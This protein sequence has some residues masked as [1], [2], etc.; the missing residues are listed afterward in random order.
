[1]PRQ[2]NWSIATPQIQ[3][4]QPGNGSL[5]VQNTDHLEQPPGREE[6]LTSSPKHDELR[7]DDLIPQNAAAASWPGAAATWQPDQNDSLFPTF[8]I[9]PTSD[10]QIET[11]RIGIGHNGPPLEDLGW[12]WLT[13]RALGGSAA[14][15]IAAIL[16]TPLNRGEVEYIASR[17]ARPYGQLSRRL[18]PGFQAHHLNQN[19]AFREVIPQNDGI[20]VG[21]RG[22]A[23]T[24][25]GTPHYMFHQSLEQFWEPYRSGGN[26]HSKA[27][28]NAMYGEALQRALQAGGLSPEE[29]SYL[30]SQAANQRASYGLIESAAVPNV[31][32]RMNLPRTAEQ[33]LQDRLRES[34]T[35]SS[36]PKRSSRAPK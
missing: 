33:R 17:Y 21:M 16:P 6:L 27:P 24:E 25:P 22:N 3:D 19:A 1:V 30:A 31:P 23:F 11:P 26:L 10:G 12:K 20:A 14:A 35:T 2:L 15:L 28:T 18:P 8:G 5:A 7:F 13:A 9:G 32:S 36:D 29:A 4:V 34:E